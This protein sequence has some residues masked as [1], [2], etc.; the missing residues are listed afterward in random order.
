MVRRAACGL[1]AVAVLCLAAC[2]SPTGPSRGPSSMAGVPLS[3]YLR[4][5]TTDTST[6]TMFVESWGIWGV[7]Y[8]AE[9]A[10]TD[11]TLWTSSDPSVARVV[12]PGRIQAVAPGEVTLT[13]TLD[14]FIKTERLRVFPGDAP[15]RVRESATLTV[16]NSSVPCCQ[17]F[18][19]GVTFEILTGYNAGRA[20]TTDVGGKLTFAG[21][22]YCGES[23]IRMSK[24]G[25]REVVRPLTWC[26]ELPQ[27]DLEM[28][29]GG[30]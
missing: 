10:V 3:I 9:R 2:S 1:L 17:N 5:W 6:Q 7:T 26:S 24:A 21:P 20:A 11:E 25:Y 4:H 14:R 28:A 18:L 16:R 30:G 12:A 27:P 15:T 13:A 19:T 29:P 22:F 8:T 23:M